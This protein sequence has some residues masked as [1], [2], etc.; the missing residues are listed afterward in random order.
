MIYPF[1]KQRA[2]TRSYYQENPCYALREPE[3]CYNSH[4]DHLPDPIGY[5]SKD[6]EIIRNFRLID[7]DFLTIVFDNKDCAELLIRVILSRN[8]LTVVRVVC[9]HVLKNLYG[10]SVRLDIYAE[11]SD[12]NAY[13]IE[14]QRDDR[15]AGV[16]RARYNSSLMDAAITD[17][18][19]DYDTL[20]ETY[21]ILITEN[22]V[23]GDGLPI[24]HLD[25]M[26]TETGRQINDGSHIIYVNSQIRDETALGRLMHD[27]W[28]TSHEDMHYD[29]LA[30]RVRYFKTEEEGVAS[31]CKAIEDLVNDRMNEAAQLASRMQSMQIARKM[32]A[33][34]EADDKV[35][36]YTGLT[37]DE[38][39]ALR[40]ERQ[41]A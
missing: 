1:H 32:I 26:I 18:G 21:V 30:N 25:R 10:R 13:N 14:V 37:L 35:A 7:D 34:G 6:L 11:D 27:F 24:Y 40:N 28:C 22:D 4:V 5:R 31:M 33:A 16:R 29:V 39:Q 17:P 2:G 36:D 20:A 23:F 38:V 41:P 19:D 9:Q 15:G 3:Q 12:G 8:D